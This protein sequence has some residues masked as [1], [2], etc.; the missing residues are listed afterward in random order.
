MAW[1]KIESKHRHALETKFA[2]AE[3]NDLR[4]HRRIEH[5]GQLFALIVTLSAIG[6]GTYAVI[7]GHPTAGTILSG[8]TVLSLVSAF[9]Y[10][11]SKRGN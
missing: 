4:A 11:R 1:V 10:G 3:V 8:A 5:L 7:N 2:D 6:C 9:I